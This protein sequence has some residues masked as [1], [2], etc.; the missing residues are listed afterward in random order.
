MTA[1]MAKYISLTVPDAL[2]AR[3]QMLLS[4]LGFGVA[5]II[6]SLGGGMLSDLIGLQHGF[7]VAAGVNLIAL[8][9][10]APRYLR[11]APLNGTAR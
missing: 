2:R 10:F 11:M 5:R 7:Y 3:G 4:I 8:I 1:T 9:A 6:G